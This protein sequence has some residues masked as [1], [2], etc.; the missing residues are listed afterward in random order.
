MKLKEL[1]KEERPR[2]KAVE[3]GIEMLS[4]R[5]LI[6]VLLRTGTRSMSALDVADELL[7]N[8][9]HLGD[10]GKSGMSELMEIS[11]VKVAKAVTLM[12]GFEL[13]RRIAFDKVKQASTIQQ[14]EDLVEWLNQQIGYE[15]QE[16]FI[17]VFLN[18]KNQVVNYQVMFKGTLTNA[19]VHPREIFKEAMR[20]GC[21]KIMC[22]HNHPSGDAT[23]SSADIELTKSIYECG[24]IAAIPLLDHIIV[25][26]NS[27]TSFRQKRLID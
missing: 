12:A 8:F 11:G 14:P 4:N 18:Q 20:L 21:A 26:R 2:E 13:G 9:D 7:G 27:F 3:Q 1:N 15:K 23:P 17:V 5:E 19:S 25:S 22:A 16:Q 6:A 24:R 10:M